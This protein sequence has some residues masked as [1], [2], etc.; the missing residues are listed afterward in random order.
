MFSY[1]RVVLSTAL[2]VALI[3]GIS[4]F[5]FA[6]PGAGDQPKPRPAACDPGASISGAITAVDGGSAI[7]GALVVVQRVLARPHAAGVAAELGS[8]ILDLAGG[9]DRHPRPHVVPV[10]RAKTDADGNYT[11]GKLCAG[12]FIVT[13]GAE[14]YSRAAYDGSDDNT[15]PDI[16]K[17]DKDSALTGISIALATR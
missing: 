15:K 16:L 12:G 6:A 17:L 8:T 3:G 14:G 11:I 5:A 1:H 4:A 9:G 2:S 7:E 10:A 13:A